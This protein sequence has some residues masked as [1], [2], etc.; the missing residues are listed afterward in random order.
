MTPKLNESS[1]SNKCLILNLLLYWANKGHARMHSPRAYSIYAAP[2]PRNRAKS[3]V[4]PN[5]AC[6]LGP[7]FLFPC[8]L[9][10][11]AWESWVVGGGWGGWERKAARSRRPRRDA[12]CPSGVT[13]Q[14]RKYG[15]SSFFS[16]SAQS[17][18]P[19]LFLERAEQSRSLA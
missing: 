2:S 7:L 14:S 6:Q 12:A 16:V 5:L 9:E 15:K 13:R 8:R 19:A 1:F 3:R 18:L 10:N 17:G 4:A 11:P